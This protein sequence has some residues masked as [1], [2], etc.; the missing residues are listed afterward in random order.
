MLSVV[1][2]QKLAVLIHDNSP[3]QLSLLVKLSQLHVV[4]DFQLVHLL[5]VFHLLGKLRLEM[6]FLLNEGGGDCL[7]VPILVLE[8]KY[9]KEYF[10]IS[11]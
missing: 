3:L 8:T 6:V 11:L 2:F 9:L 1:F 4:D 5:I 7:L 10:A